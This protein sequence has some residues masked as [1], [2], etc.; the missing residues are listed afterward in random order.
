V[1]SC[2]SAD[3]E[4]L[5]SRPRL[6]GAMVIEPLTRPVLESYLGRNG[7]RLGV[8]RAALDKDA[9]LGGHRLAAVPRSA[10]TDGP[11]G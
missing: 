4:L 6:Q 10:G 2:R 8:L 3:C 5:S 11:R 9:A 7:D 1:I